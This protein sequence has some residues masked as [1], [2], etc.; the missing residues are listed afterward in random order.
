MKKL[1]VMLSFVFVFSA[2]SFA[3]ELP[4]PKMYKVGD[5]E[6][7]AIADFVGERDLSIFDGV[8][9]KI[10]KKY[11]PSGKAPAAVMTYLIK[12]G[13]ELVLIDTGFGKGLMEGLEK[14]NVKPEDIKTILITH[15]HGDHIG[16]LVKDGKA[17]FS[18]AK[19][20]I[21][22]IEHDFWTSEES[23]KQFPDRQSSFDLAKKT[24]GICGAAAEV[25]NYD[26]MVTANIKALDASGHTPGQA[27]FLIESGGEKLL[28]IADMMHVE[29]LQFPRP[30]I[31]SNYDMDLQKAAETREKYLKMSAEENIAVA[32]MHLSYP[33]VVEV[34]KAKKAKDGY[35]FKH[36]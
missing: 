24:V 20:K 19:I 9:K 3:Q 25:F 28:C 31:S 36:K 29:A 2:V 23:A 21:G 16:G 34:T 17:A 13:E 8:D 32:G 35:I 33:G 12:N 18:N 10:L 7:W 30:D 1:I 5:M 22:K 6:V 26:D 11:V 14:L 4:E 27:A 15:M